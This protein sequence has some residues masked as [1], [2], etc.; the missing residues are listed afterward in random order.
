VAIAACRGTET[1]EVAT[2]YA[3]GIVRE[4]SA[5]QSGDVLTL[6]QRYFPPKELVRFGLHDWRIRDWYKTPPTLTV[7]GLAFVGSPDQTGDATH[8]PV[9]WQWVVAWEDEESE[10]ES[11][12]C[13]ALTPGG[14]TKIV[15]FSDKPV[16]IRWNVIVKAARYYVYRGRNGEFGFVGTVA[17]PAVPAGSSPTTV[18]FR[19]DGGEPVYSDSPRKWT[20]PFQS[21]LAYPACGAY[22]DDRFM[23]GGSLVEPRSLQGSAVADYNNFDQNV[24]MKANDPIWFA[25]TARRFEEI[26]WMVPLER[27]IVGTSEGEWVVGGAGDEAL[28]FDSIVARERS[29][30]GSKRLQP[31]VGGEGVLYV[32]TNGQV[33]R[34]F[35]YLSADS[36]WGGQDLT[37]HAGHLLEGYSIVDWAYAKEPRTVV[38]LVRS[39]GVLLSCTFIREQGP[40][41]F[42]RH[43]LPHRQADH[44][45][46]DE[47]LRGAALDRDAGELLGCR[48]PRLRQGLLGCGDE[49]GER[50]VPSR[51]P[52]RW[53]VG[54]RL[55][56]GHLH[57]FRRVDHF[58]RR[59]GYFD[60]GRLGPNL[61]VRVRGLPGRPHEAQDRREGR[62]RVPGV[63][64]PRRYGGLRQDRGGPHEQRVSPAVRRRELDPLGTGRIRLESGRALRPR[65]HSAVAGRDPGT[66]EGCRMS[67]RVQ[68]VRARMEHVD[69]IAPRLSERGVCA[70]FGLGF[71]TVKGALVYS[72]EHSRDRWAIVVDGK[73]EV[74]G[75]ITDWDPPQAWLAST[76]AAR[77]VRWSMHRAVK[78]TLDSYIGHGLQVVVHAFDRS[79][80]SWMSRLGFGEWQLRLVHLEPFYVGRMA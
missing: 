49:H 9:E 57:R 1:H 22:F 29:T 59:G 23:T 16:T 25:L 2:P 48:G 35:S 52:D 46:D 27:L 77:S 34:D 42:G 13:A 4:L 78:K 60:R 14:T 19:D 72:F 54:G 31:I 70:I 24:V 56:S 15:L 30:R 55:V 26:R 36:N 8:P 75:G 18:D 39:D 65:A 47:A 12:P 64:G 33:V 50:P 45:R 37:E 68:V 32:Q 53:G 17:Q 3:A 44:Q 73:T 79:A 20:N 74:V 28:S 69:A 11:K 80:K 7:A 61:P 40:E 67:H 43:P 51:G 6:F 21:D 62:A 38:W 66:D 76:D 41:R 5:V 63:D 10:L 71:E 58:H